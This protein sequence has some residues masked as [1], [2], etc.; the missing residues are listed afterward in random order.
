M[1]SI[2]YSTGGWPRWGWR[3]GD[4]GRCTFNWRKKTGR[5][6]T[7]WLKLCLYIFLYEMLETWKEYWLAECCWIYVH[8]LFFFLNIE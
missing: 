4:R 8:M 3:L 6:R 2:C 5:K 1:P 7:R